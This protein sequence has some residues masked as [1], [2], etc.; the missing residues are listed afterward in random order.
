M[1]KRHKRKG[2]RD[3]NKLEFGDLDEKQYHILLLLLEIDTERMV[4]TGRILL[5]A[6]ATHQSFL[7]DECYLDIVNG[8]CFAAPQ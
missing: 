5:S 7:V 8:L 4:F 1:I 3:T 6:F 2:R